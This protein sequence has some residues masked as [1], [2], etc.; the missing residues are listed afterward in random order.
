M[1]TDTIQ[2][3]VSVHK[4]Q[5]D[6]KM[7]IKAEAKNLGF[8]LFGVTHPVKPDHL[9][10]FEA[11]L[12]G[13]NHADMGYLSRPDTLAKRRDPSRLMPDCKSILC[14][15][16]PYPNAN[17][18]NFDDKR[19]TGRIASYAWRQ[20][21]HIDLPDRI[22][23]MISRVEE[24]LDRKIT[25]R[26]F[27]D[28]S[29]ILERDL[30]WRA[31]LGW[32]GKNSCLIHPDVGSFFL[33]AEVFVDVELESDQSFNADRCGTC[34]RCITACPTGCILPDRT[35]DSRRCI[36]YLTIENKGP[37][38]RELRPAMGNWILGCDICQ[39]VCPWNRLR[40]GA[41]S[42]QMA[43]D[44][45]VQ[46]S[47]ISLIDEITISVQEFRQKFGQSPVLRAKRKGCLRNITVALGNCRAVNAIPVLTKALMTESDPVI[48]SHCVW[49]LGQIGGEVSY[50][51]LRQALPVEED[52]LVREEIRTILG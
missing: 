38:P 31:G 7:V 18:L 13:G 2:E 30:A 4:G 40:V 16:F 25:Y 1:P 43:N 15:A 3:P 10:S 34:N 20:D 19:L 14:L 50:S 12:S 51:A 35:I 22:E 44:Q 21:Y 8:S 9:S 5:N 36:S 52:I 17:L 32:I 39:M 29:P 45:M 11:W 48:R 46:G 33:L 6:I 28:S 23:K 37:I 26:A 47:L 24:K 42:G 27:T 41:I 49:A